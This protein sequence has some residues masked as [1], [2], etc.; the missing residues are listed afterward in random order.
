MTDRQPLLDRIRDLEAAVFSLENKLAVRGYENQI[1]DLQASSIGLAH[2]VK[3]YETAL[4]EIAW[5]NNSEWQQDRAKH[6][7]AKMRGV[8]L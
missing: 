4:E 7:L 2:K 3:M 6:V 5:S 1:D 8:E